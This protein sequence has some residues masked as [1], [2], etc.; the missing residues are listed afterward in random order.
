MGFLMERDKRAIWLVF[1]LVSSLS[2]SC[3]LEGKEA[4]S[5]AMV[6]IPGGPFIGGSDDGY[7]NENPKE[8]LDIVE[9][10]IDTNE[11]SVNDYMMCVG[12]RACSA[13]SMSD[14]D[15]NWGHSERGNHPLNC[16]SW[17]QATAYCKWM[18]KRLPTQTQWE[19][20]A[21]GVRG[22]VYPWG[23]TRANC[24]LAV[25]DGGKTD[26]GPMSGCG[27]RSTWPT[28]SRPDGASPYGVQDMGGNVSEWTQ[29]YYTVDQGGE[30]RRN[31][32][33]CLGK[34][35]RV[36]RGGSWTGDDLDLRSA[37]RGQ[38]IADKGYVSIGFRCARFY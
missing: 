8:R 20:A 19:K 18:G 17:E 32:R 13:P 15:C 25:M 12:A 35:A 37:R 5:K 3:G 28:G 24:D 21:R 38:G 9:Y 14:S 31:P 26:D 16:V 34:G 23:N 2:Q 33:G 7:K 30:Q 11:V 36:V 29:D 1:A 4:S 27:K 10:W 6:R 22:R